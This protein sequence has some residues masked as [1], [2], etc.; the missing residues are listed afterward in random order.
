MKKKNVKKY[1][2]MV[3]ALMLM[4]VVSVAGTLAYLSATTEKVTNTFAIGKLFDEQK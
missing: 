3:V 2:L 4:C 1:L